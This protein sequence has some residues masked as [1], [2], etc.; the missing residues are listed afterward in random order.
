MHIPILNDITIIF[1]FAALSLLICSRAKIPE[2]LGYLATGILVGP[3][4]LGL[5]HAVHEV[6]MMAEIGVVLLLF[7][8][9]LEF[10]LAMLI[11]LK[12]PALLGGSLQ[13]GLTMGLVTG[14][15]YFF[16]M[17]F[18]LALFM[19]MMASLSSTAIVLKAL[20]SRGDID[21]PYGR[22][23]AAVLIFQDIAVIPMMLA[24]PM[25]AGQGGSGADM[26]LL[27]LK[28]VGIV[29]LL[30]F[31]ARTIVP[32]LLYHAAS[33][34][35]REL[36]LLTVVLVCLGVAWITSS[37]G[38]SLALG[39]FLAGIV[40]SESG[41]GQQALGDVVPFK[42]VFTGFFFVSI[43]M[44][45]DPEVVMAKPVIIIAATAGVVLI[46]FIIMGGV[47][48]LIGYPSRVAVQSGVSMAQ[49]GEF[50]FILGAAGAAAG[51]LDDNL[52]PV[53]IAVTVLSM[54]VTPFLM[55]FAP[56]L[57][58]LSRKLPI[59][60]SLQ[61]GFFYNPED[62]KEHLSDHLIIVG[63][64]VNGRNIAETATKAGIKYM[65]IEMNPDTVRKE[66]EN[67][68]PIFFGDAS[69][70]AVLEHAHLESARA[71]VITIPDPVVVRRTVET[72]RRE[73]STIHILARTRYLSEAEPLREL[74]A[75]E[76]V[77]E[78]FE[79]SVELF[80]LILRKYLVP[81]EDID[82]LISGLRQENRSNASSPEDGATCINLAGMDVENITVPVGSQKTGRSVRELDIRF[83]FKVNLLAVRRGGEIIPNPGS[84]FILE[85][86]DVLVLLGEPEHLTRFAKTL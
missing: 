63:F 77:V 39:A 12:R 38:L 9:G 33:S 45:L 16:G 30:F 35:N 56:R 15:A 47:V 34:R 31:G 66:Q 54:A 74:G 53:I 20:A 85:D 59:P 21:S 71:I 5:I 78:E 72:A 3:N 68:I 18:P 50:S 43:G 32:R 73:N 69:Q 7:T 61:K 62:A 11:S 14:G 84:D 75:D 27:L 79:T 76:V 52:Y 19:G 25:L 86:R 51:L 46:K 10:S 2:I 1:L 23:S 37:A 82:Q 6:E 81:R 80:R 42:D 4:G 36:F 60:S 64:G 83:K 49:V 55:D 67:D 29:I 40:V 41:Y 65:I 26:G 17:D 44:L 48:N 22:I 57:A 28:A 70:P 13:V 58:E 8:I 24:V